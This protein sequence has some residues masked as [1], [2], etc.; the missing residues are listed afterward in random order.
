MAEHYIGLKGTGNDVEYDIIKET[1]K[2]YFLQDELGYQFWMPKTAFSTD[3]SIT[4][5][6]Y[7]LLC[8]KMKGR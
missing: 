4:E 8:E 6:G 7:N 5:Y 1:D 2:A 3:G